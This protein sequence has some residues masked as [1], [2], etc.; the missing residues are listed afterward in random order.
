MP[1]I[2]ASNISIS[3]PIPSLI[4]IITMNLFEIYE[5]EFIMISY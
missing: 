5:S 1:K 2:E 3:S 4:F